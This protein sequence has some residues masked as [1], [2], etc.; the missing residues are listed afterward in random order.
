MDAPKLNPELRKQQRQVVAALLMLLVGIACT[1]VLYLLM[2][3]LGYAANAERWG[4][5]FAAPTAG[6]IYVATK[7]SDAILLPFERAWS[8]VHKRLLS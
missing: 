6:L 2:L 8:W 4:S 3:A 1:F 7:K 5:M